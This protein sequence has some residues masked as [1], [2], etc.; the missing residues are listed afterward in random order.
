MRKVLDNRQEL[1][2]EGGRNYQNAEGYPWLSVNIINCDSH[3]NYPSTFT[4]S[5]DSANLIEIRCSDNGSGEPDEH[6]RGLAREIARELGWQA[7]QAIADGE[8]ELR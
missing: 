8:A 6:Y 1:R 4:Q 2:A 3:G 5:E 7:V